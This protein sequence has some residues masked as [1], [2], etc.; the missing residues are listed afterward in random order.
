MVVL[1][2][3]GTQKEKRQQESVLYDSSKNLKSRANIVREIDLAKVLKRR[4]AFQDKFDKA[5]WHTSL[6]VISVTGP[7]FMNWA[8]GVG[9]GG[10]IDLV[11]HLE[12]F[13][14]KT[15]VCWLEDN[16]SSSV[17]TS[18][19]KKSLP[20]KSFT[21]PKRDD[22]K[23]PGVTNYLEHHRGIPPRIINRLTSTGKLFADYRGNA[24]FVLLGKGKRAVGAELRGTTNLRWRGMAKGSKKSRGFFYIRNQASRKIVLCESAIDAISYFVLQPDCLALSTSGAH[25]NPAWLPILIRRGFDVFCGFDSNKTGDIIAKKMMGQYPSVKRL[26]PFKNDWNDV[27]RS[28]ARLI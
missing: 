11:I 22:N 17:Q 10:A 14:F 5:K 23:M 18:N 25:P 24:V 28:K 21:L 3:F 26:R 19:E 27:L 4:G 6:G 1:G 20:Q 9:G 8:Q 16:F 7:K 13:D 12:K 2:S 15:A